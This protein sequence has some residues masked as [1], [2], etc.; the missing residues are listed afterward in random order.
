T[1][2]L[3]ELI[4]EN[5][6]S[7][8]NWSEISSMIFGGVFES[9]L[10][11]EEKRKGGMHYTSI[12]N[13]HKVIDPLFLEELKEELNEIKQLKQHA[14]IKRRALEFQNKLASLT[15]L[16]PAAGSGNFLTETYIALRELENEALVLIHG[17]NVLLDTESDL[18]KVSLD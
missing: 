15:F 17:D 12:P 8:F 13:N 5:A 6:S 2:H 16:D 11:P 14:A 3:C 10:N 7:D 18:I 9:T 1:D 4:L